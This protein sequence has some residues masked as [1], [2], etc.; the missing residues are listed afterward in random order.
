ME[1]KLMAIYARRSRKNIQA[2]SPGLGGILMAL[3]SELF[4]G[5]L[6]SLTPAEMREMAKRRPAR[7]ST[8]IWRQMRRD[9]VMRR[10]D[11]DV[12][13]DTL[14]EAVTSGIEEDTDDLILSIASDV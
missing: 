13:H 14:L 1:E 7:V 5:C 9:G 8:N 2:I 6:G 11:A 10:T 4:K 12:I 3:L